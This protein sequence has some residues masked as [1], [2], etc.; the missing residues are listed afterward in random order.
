MPEKTNEEVMKSLNQIEETIT[1]TLNDQNAKLTE[2]EKK[3]QETP[4]NSPEMEELKKQLEDQQKAVQEVVEFYKN[5]DT[6]TFAKKARGL[7]EHS[8]E[9]KK[10]LREGVFKSLGALFASKGNVD[11]FYSKLK[12]MKADNRYIEKQLN[13]GTDTEGGFLVIPEYS[14]ALIELLQPNSAMRRAGATIMPMKTNNMKW[15]VQTSAPVAEYDGEMEEIVPSEMAFSDKELNWKRLTSLVPFSRELDADAFVN[16]QSFIQAKAREQFRLKEDKTFFE[17]DGTDTKKPLGLY[18][19][20]NAANIIDGNLVDPNTLT[21]AQLKAWIRNMWLKVRNAYIP[22]TTPAWF[23]TPTLYALLR[24]VEKD[25]S[26][27]PVFKSIENNDTLYNAP[28][29][30]ADNLTDDSKI[31]FGDV[32][33]FIIGERQGIEV[34]YSDQATINWATKGTNYNLFQRNMAA[35]RFTARHDTM[36]MYD[37]A[38]SILEN[39]NWTGSSLFV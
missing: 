14:R 9:G 17:S 27:N 11:R 2:L 12:S 23:M 6:D 19:A 36:L 25:V 8:E 28:I 3:M 10:E 32:A 21:A 24:D 1:K 7:D 26:Q 15:T 13:E 4:D 33:Q 34:A 22:M 5:M 35:L 31:Y 18:G 16:L 30:I 37:K 39:I 38:F 29:T 20:T